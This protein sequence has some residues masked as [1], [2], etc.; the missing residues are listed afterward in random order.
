MNPTT[1][2][3][4]KQLQ[5]LLIIMANEGIHNAARGMA[6]MVGDSVRVSR[7]V[8]RQVPLSDIPN[9]LGSPE[10]ETVGIYLRTEGEIAV[11]IMQIVPYAYAL[12][13]VDRML[14]YPPNTTQHLGTL[15]RSALAALGNLAGSFFLNAVASATGLSIRPTPPAV[16]VDMV[17]A[18]LD[19]LLATPASGESERVLMVQATFS[20]GERQAL[21]EFWVVPDHT[22]LEIVARKGLKPTC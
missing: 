8:V 12:E 21:V 6:A 18:I 2:T 14:G 16:M 13:L 5:R 1:E 15:E 10:I 11:Q 17:G 4:D 19:I 22:T 3:Q 9:L 7:P 20:R